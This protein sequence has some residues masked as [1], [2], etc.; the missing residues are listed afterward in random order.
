MSLFS[1]GPLI[2]P[3][4]LGLL[5]TLVMIRHR[6]KDVAAYIGRP[7]ALVVGRMVALIYAAVITVFLVINA[8]SMLVQDAVAVSLPVEEFWPEPYPWV[9]FTPEPAASVV[10]GGFTTAE[11]MVS[12]LD[13]DA[14]WV[15]TAAGAV[16]GL[17]LLMIA[18]V[19]A[20][21]CHRLLGGTPFRPLLARSISWAAGV[22]A[23]GGMAWQI[24][25]AIGGNM[26]STQVLQLTSWMSSP[27]TADLLDFGASPLEELATGLP[28]Q[29]MGFSV[30]AW[31]L[32]L[33]LVLAAVAAAFR[34]SERLQ[35]ETEGLV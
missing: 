7:L 20:L 13:M 26:A 18:L 3:I 35:K 11:V 4:I 12:G 1:A 31:P 33:G 23:I 2:V 22:V 17:T 8:V 5:I 10:G 19:F 6:S 24:L 34:S 15:L 27:P 28:L 29:S 30:E 16:Q 25:Y 21:L 9:T 32:L 14:R